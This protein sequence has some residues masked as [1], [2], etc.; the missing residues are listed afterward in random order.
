MNTSQSLK[1]IEHICINF[2]GHLEL[3]E[4]HFVYVDI[5]LIKSLEDLRCLAL[6]EALEEA[7]F[8]VVEF[9]LQ[10]RLQFL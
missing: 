10:P 2:L 8:F 1:R 4:F 3:L 9:D 7:L 5:H 6:D